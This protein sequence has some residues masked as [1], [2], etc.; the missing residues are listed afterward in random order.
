MAEITIYSDKTNRELRDALEVHRQNK[1]FGVGPLEGIEDPGFRIVR[2]VRALED[3]T[4][5]YSV[6]VEFGNPTF[7][8]SASGPVT[9]TFEAY[10]PQVTKHALL[11]SGTIENGEVVKAS[12]HYGKWYIDD[13][14][15]SQCHTAR[16][17]VLSVDE[18]TRVALCELLAVP[19][20]CSDVPGSSLVDPFGTVLEVCDPSGCFFNEPEDEIFG[21]MGGAHYM[22]PLFE[23]TC[24]PAGS[25]SGSGTGTSGD[26]FVPQWEVVWL[27]CAPLSC[28]A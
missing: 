24:Q 11:R 28:D 16:F 27:C 21:R 4:A 22:L 12:L 8:D 2:M 18:D 19:A 25:G 7:D 10:T 17:R 15:S 20:G 23:T 26:D 6:L 9:E 13:S 14:G 3:A 1:T 5:P